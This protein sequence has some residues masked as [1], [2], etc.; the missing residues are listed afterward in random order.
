M[1]TERLTGITNSVEW[2]DRPEGRH[3]RVEKDAR[4]WPIL[5]ASPSGSCDGANPMTGRLCALGYHNG[6]HRDAF[7]AEWLDD[8]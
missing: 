6:Y 1:T 2:T 4:D 3:S 7:G 8:E 5:K